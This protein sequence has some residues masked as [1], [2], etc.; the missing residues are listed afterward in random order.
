MNWIFITE[1]ILYLCFGLLAGVQVLRFV[2]ESKR[3]SYYVPESMIRFS[4][5]LIAVLSFFPLL[6]LV[7]L[8]SE[9]SDVGFGVLFEA[10]LF[11]FNV[12]QAWI[13]TLFTCGSLLLLQSIR[14]YVQDRRLEYLSTVL[15]FILFL[16]FAWASHCTVSY[17]WTGFA[18]HGLH[19]LAVS[20]WMGILLVIGWFAQDHQN[21]QAF[22]N[23]FTPLAVSCFL[24][25]LI[26]GLTLMSWLVP[27]VV[28]SWIVS[29]GQSLLIKHLF[30]VPLLVFAILNSVFVRRKMI[31][32]PTFRPIPWIRAESI[33]GMTVFAAMAVLGMQS[34]TENLK[35]VIQFE[36]PSRLFEFF[37]SSPISPD[38]TIQLIPTVNGIVMWL[39]SLLCLFMM[40]TVVLR[41][42]H[43]WSALGF[44]LLFVASAYLG[45]MFSIL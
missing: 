12:G 30:I 25:T 28:N 45:F 23:W 5:L 14:K 10:I 41:K 7:F 8:F 20:V 13:I 42:K 29:Y 38:T 4:V 3:P 6:R 40:C 17:Q 44:G 39:L 1:L 34:P 21:W 18:T 36:K 24:I 19:F 16:A 32:D 11:D 31:S 43:P 26:A 27:D 22:L 9:D 37:Y 35:A 33:S 15:T 2:P